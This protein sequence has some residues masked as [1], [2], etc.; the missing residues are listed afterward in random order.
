[1]QGF[2][3]IKGLV[4]QLQQLAKDAGHERPLMVGIDQENGVC[5]FFSRTGALRRASGLVS[6]FNPVNGQC[7]TQ[8]YVIPR[9]NMLVY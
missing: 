2:E 6:A 4:A 7:G 5:I 1:M 3:Q 8:L 9:F